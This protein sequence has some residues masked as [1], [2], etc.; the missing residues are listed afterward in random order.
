MAASRWWCEWLLSLIAIAT[1]LSFIFEM[2]T[3]SEALSHSLTH[4]LGW[5][6]WQRCVYVIIYQ[7]HRLTHQNLWIV[8]KICTIFLS[9]CRLS[10]L[11]SYKLMSPMKC[12]TFLCCVCVSVANWSVAQCL[13]TSAQ[14]ENWEILRYREFSS[15]YFLFFFDESKSNTI[16]FCSG[17][18]KFI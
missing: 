3:N 6:Q 14:C 16:L 17:W 12:Y 18:N 9:H 8:N 4:S 11:A 2:M 1:R 10:L 7:F 13:P 15:I 5:R